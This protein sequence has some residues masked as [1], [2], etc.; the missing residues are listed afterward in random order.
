LS[1]ADPQLCVAHLVRRSNP[2]SA[3]RGF[4]ESY[5]RFP[6]GM[7]HDLLIIFKGFPRGGGL[8]PYETCLEGVAHKRVFFSDYGFDV[9][10]Y[11]KVAR[12]QPYRY[13]MF[14][15]SFSR[16]LA[17]G[18]LELLFR[19][20]GKPRVGLVG[21][22]GSHQSI[23]SDAP[24]LWA[25]RRA[26]VNAL[27]RA[28]YALSIWRRFPEFPNHHLRTNG[29]LASREVLLRVRHA[30]IL[31]KWAAYRFESGVGS[32]TRQVAEAGLTPLVAG[33]DGRAYEPDAWPESHTFWISRQENLLVSDNQTRAYA[34]GDDAVRERLA[35]FAWRR[36]PDGTPRAQAPGARP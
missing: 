24:L 27:R 32:M 6:A 21:A 36:R 13:F 11:L 19:H 15:N 17:P 7:P 1:V 8:A 33:A 10:P 22:T 14:L 9:R 35:Y 16:L 30:P 20:A 5:A 2:L 26:A 25:E 18:W 3:L 31:T 4:V 12:E 29:F 23:V 34:D 28:R